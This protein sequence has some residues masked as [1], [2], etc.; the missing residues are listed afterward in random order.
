MTT[1]NTK[2]INAQGLHARPATLFCKEAG[3]FQSDIK[4]IC[5]DKEGNAKSLIALLA[6]GLTAGAELQVVAEGADEEAAAKHMA[7]FIGSFQE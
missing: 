2:L 3:Q 4:L 5:G 6:M 1:I 7:D